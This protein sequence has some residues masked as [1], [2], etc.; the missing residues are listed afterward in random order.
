MGRAT[1]RWSLSVGIILLYMPFSPAAL[2]WPYE[3]AMVGVWSLM[4][5]GFYLWSNTFHREESDRI[6]AGQLT[7]LAKA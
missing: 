1:P 6:L 7:P 3:W 4:G 2:V 5:L